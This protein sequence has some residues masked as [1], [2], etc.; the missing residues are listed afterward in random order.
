MITSEVAKRLVSI[1][2]QENYDDSNVGRLAYSYDSTPNK[3]AMPDAVVAPR[4]TK[5]VSEIVKILLTSIPF[6]FT[7]AVQVLI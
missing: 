6:R 4:T 7:L 2:G 3:Q 5:E 1:V